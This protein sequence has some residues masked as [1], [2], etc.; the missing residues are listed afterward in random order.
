MR[1]L[2][3]DRGEVSRVEARLLPA[4]LQSPIRGPATERPQLGSKSLPWGYI[5][6]AGRRGCSR[7][8][9]R[10]PR[11]EV[12]GAVRR[13]HGVHPQ[14]LV[15]AAGRFRPPPPARMTCRR[16]PTAQTDVPATGRGPNRAPAVAAGRFRLPAVA[17]GRVWPTVADRLTPRRQTAAQTDVSA[18]VRGP[19]RAVSVAA[20]RVWFPSVAAGRFRPPPPARLCIRRQPVRQTV[21]LTTRS[22]PKRHLAVVECTVWSTHCRRMHSLAGGLSLDAQSGSPAVAGCTVWLARRP[23][24]RPRFTYGPF[25][26]RFAFA[27]LV[28]AH[29]GGKPARSDPRSDGLILYLP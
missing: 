6:A 28:P 13:R 14:V 23:A 16:Q 18:T 12:P 8:C 27:R 3:S 26:E 25:L 5:L 17:D 11:A 22:C 15:V 29:N 21:S 7:V 2:G 20:G 4:G 9:G 1:P 10:R 24:T 19:N